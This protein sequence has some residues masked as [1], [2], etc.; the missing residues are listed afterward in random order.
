M[1][2]SHTVAIGTITGMSNTESSKKT[3]V[4]HVSDFD[5]FK[6]FLGRAAFRTHPVRRYVFPACPGWK[7]LLRETVSFTV[8]E[9]AYDT[10]IFLVFTHYT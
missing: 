7:T 2:V 8:D 4:C 3:A 9:S 5:H 6:V 1:P 10:H